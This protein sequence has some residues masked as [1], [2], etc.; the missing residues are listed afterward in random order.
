MDFGAAA[1]RIL[2]ILPVQDEDLHQALSS[3][4]LPITPIEMPV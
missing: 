1:E 4:F 2:D 3:Y